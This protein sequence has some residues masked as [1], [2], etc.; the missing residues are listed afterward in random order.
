MMFVKNT[1]PLD[2]LAAVRARGAN[3]REMGMGVKGGV[4]FSFSFFHFFWVLPPFLGGGWSGVA[5]GY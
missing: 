1:R 4:F 2:L 3:R 5:T